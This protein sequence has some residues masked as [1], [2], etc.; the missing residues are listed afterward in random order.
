M[1]AISSTV[2][3]LIVQPAS[4]AGRPAAAGCLLCAAA[5]A[6]CSL[7]MLAKCSLKCFAMSASSVMRSPFT[8]RVIFS[9]FEVRL[10]RSSIRLQSFFWVTSSHIRLL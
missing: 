9:A 1:F 3:V 2:V 8:V 4:A 5:G 6:L 7:A 10:E